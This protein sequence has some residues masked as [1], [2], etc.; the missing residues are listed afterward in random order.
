MSALRDNT[1]GS[2]ILRANMRDLEMCAEQLRFSLNKCAVLTPPFSP[3]ALESIEALTSRFARTA[4]VFTHKA[5][6][7]LMLYL[8]EDTVTFVD[9][10]NF[11]EKLGIAESANKVVE[12]RE[13][14]NEIAHEYAER[15]TNELLDACR[16]LSPTLFTLIASL[17]TYVNDRLG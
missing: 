5:V 16:Q 14:R 10:T 4:D 15:E 11:L 7:S 9:T 12:I 2:E 6:K 13:L 3:E 17:Q 8:Q 1:A